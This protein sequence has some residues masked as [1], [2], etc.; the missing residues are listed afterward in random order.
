MLKGWQRWAYFS[1]WLIAAGAALQCWQ[2]TLWLRLPQLNLWL[3]V[4]VFCSTFLL[5]LFHFRFYHIKR[6]ANDRQVFF[7]QHRMGLLVQF[8]IAV[9]LLAF[10][11]YQTG[12]HVL[13][14]VSLLALCAAA[15]TYFI[16]KPRHHGIFK[17]NGIF[18][19][20]TLSFTWTAVT[21]IL[22]I[23]AAGENILE[24]RH[25]FYTG[26][27]WLFML[28][29]CLPFDIRDIKGD[30]RAGS[31]TIPVLLGKNNTFSLC[32]ACLFL[33]AV[34]PFAGV[35]AGWY[36]VKI[37]LLNLPATA[38]TAWCTAYSHRHLQDDF[39]WFLLD[40]NFIL[41]AGIIGSALIF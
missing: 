31:K 2:T 5:Y 13:V 32:Y 33:H 23:A 10:S 3:Y 12:V 17:Y 4:F 38:L 37:L 26:I 34:L 9:L 6:P 16:L 40:S 22:P 27:R 25:L 35:A 36:P 15:Y 7:R 14:P 20:L 18:K 11:T 8:F 41:R 19:I 28:A 39:S 30:E 21:S 24:A 1:Q 29:I